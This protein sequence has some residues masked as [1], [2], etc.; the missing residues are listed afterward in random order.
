MA[1]VG[2]DGHQ[3][4]YTPLAHAARPWRLCALLPGTQDK[5]WWGVSW[6]LA[7]EAERLGV[8]IGIYQ[9]G[10]YDR[11]DVQKAQLQACRGLKADAYILSAISTDGLDGDIAAIADHHQPLVDLINGVGS[12]YVSAH[13]LSNFH[14]NGRFGA[15]YILDHRAAWERASGHPLKVGWLPG[16]D[17]VE[18]ANAMEISA[19]AIL[20]RAGVAVVHGGYGPTALTAQ[21]DLVRA[22]FERE[23]DL[24]VVFGNAVAIQAAANFLR[25]RHNTT[26]RLVATYSTG[27]VIDLIRDGAV[28]LAASDSPILQARVAVDLAVRALEG[29]PHGVWNV[30]AV[31]RLDRD[32][33]AGYDLSRV[34]VPDG[35]R[36]QLRP[37]P[38][39]GQSLA[40]PR[41]G[42]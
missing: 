18:W 26:T 37:L 42:S 25:S 1:A 3:A 11:L 24:D 29:K 31:D 20:R 19:L 4:P 12:P 32:H 23:P 41:L 7:H 8:T 22:L 6:G 17:G 5:F 34:A 27:T 10:G 21:M 30:M 35:D 16:P 15:E 38:P 14:E 9:A 2:S 36:F 33:L 13:I 39:P 28:D 40:S